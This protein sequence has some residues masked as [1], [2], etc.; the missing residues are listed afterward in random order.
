M[1]GVEHAF[2]EFTL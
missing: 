2:N 1:F